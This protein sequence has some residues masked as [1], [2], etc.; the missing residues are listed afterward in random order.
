MQK[1]E[2]GAAA[3]P[4][5]GS[6][7]PA[8]LMRTLCGRITHWSPATER[9]YGYTLDE[10]LG[11]DAHQMLRTTFWRTQ[12]EI[13]VELLQRK[14][15]DGALVHRRADGRVIVTAHHWHL[16]HR[17]PSICELHTEILPADER[18]A[19]QV[20][21]VIGLVGHALRQPLTA[22]DAYVDAANR[23]ARPA[24]P[25]MA[26]LRLALAATAAQIIRLREGMDLFRDVG[27]DL[28]PIDSKTTGLPPSR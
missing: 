1:T 16:H 26:N 2:N 3:T 7:P 22:I 27:R 25:D 17:E 10:A 20:A 23:V 6:N 21:D 9:R 13:E 19:R 18:A 5:S 24:W 8:L 14:S 28:I 4:Q 11:Q 12:H 15:W